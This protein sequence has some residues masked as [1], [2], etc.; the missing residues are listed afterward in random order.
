LTLRTACGVVGVLLL[1]VMGGAGAFGATT[2][3]PRIVSLGLAP[4]T[5]TRVSTVTANVR[6][7]DPGH[8][9]TVRYRWLR[10]GKT[11]ADARSQSIDLARH[12]F[13]KGDRVR[14][15][16]TAVAG[17]R[18]TTRTSTAVVVG[19]AAPDVTSL[20]IDPSTPTRGDTLSARLRA[21]D[22]DGDHLSQHRTWSWTCPGQASGSVGAS[23]IAPSDLGIGHGCRVSLSDRVSDGRRTVVATAPAVVI[24]DQAPSLDHASVAY[25]PATATATIHAA[26]VDA[27]GDPLQTTVRWTVDGFDA[28][29]SATLDLAAADAHTGDVIAALVRVTDSQ[30]ASS[31]W[32]AATPA[33]ISGGVPARP[34][35]ND[36]QLYADLDGSAVYGV[37]PVQS[38]P[39]RLY[40]IDELGLGWSADA[41]ATWSSASGPCRADG[42]ALAYAPSAPETVYAGCFDSGTYRSDDGGATWQSIPITTGSASLGTLLTRGAAGLAVDPTNPDVVYAVCGN[43]DSIWRTTNAGQTWEVVGTDPDWGESVAIDPDDPTHV[44][45]GSGDGILVSHDG[46]DNW[47]G[48][49]GSGPTEV[50]FDSG[51]PSQLWAIARDAS[52][53]SLLHST[54]GGATWTTI[55]SSPTHLTALAVAG[56]VIDVGDR[57]GNVSRSTDAGSTWSTSGLRYSGGGQVDSLA[58]DPTDANHVY[59]GFDGGLLGGLEFRPDLPQGLRPYTTVRLD[60]VTTTPTSATLHATV[61]PLLP[62]SI[63]WVEWHWGSITANDNTAFTVVTGSAGEQAASTTLTNLT[64]DTTYHLI[65]SG[66]FGAPDGQFISDTQE[67][68]FTTPP[69]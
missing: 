16:V 44:V 56:G 12:A 33:T 9:V 43:C 55:A 7:K 60:S 38:T 49:Y 13:R 65:A 40:V 5:P 34:P 52:T 64:P 36:W 17:L 41:G 2:A 15:R 51:G 42:V 32:V 18:S 23:T 20:A 45:V 59:V 61:A 69:A 22:I 3:P 8:R 1:G 58:V 67:F 63:G 24:G 19:D 62:G 29:G 28:G 39:G 14:V 30:G 6:T 27:D 21:S 54:D 66:L 48:P 35:M 4:R 50:A 57:L 25:D 53:P 10:N 37:L 68:T 46:G 31:G 11:V 26:P 47:A